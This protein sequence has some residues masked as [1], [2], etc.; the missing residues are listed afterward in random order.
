M[1][2]KNTSDISILS[3][4]DDKMAQDPKV[5]DPKKP[6]KSSAKQPETLTEIPVDISQRM[7]VLTKWVSGIGCLTSHATIFQSYMWRHI[8]V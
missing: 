7:W 4:E 5:P 1:Y 2:E 8:N 6:Q 3:Y